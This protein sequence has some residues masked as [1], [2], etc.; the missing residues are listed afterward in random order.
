MNR[1]AILHIPK[2]NYAFPVSKRDFRVR[3]RAGKGDLDRVRLVIGNQYLWNTR[4]EFEMEKFGSDALFD[5]YEVEYHCTDTR[6]GYYF[7]LNQG[8]E[9]LIY[10]ENGFLTPGS[11]DIDHDRIGFVHFQFPFI[12]GIDVHKK[13]SWVNETVFYQIF[14]ERFC[15]GDPALSPED[16]TPWGE[17]PDRRNYFG[18]DLQGIIQKLPYLADLGVNAL[19]LTPI[20]EALS[21]HKYDTI[22]YTRIDPHF[23]DEST[24]VELVQKAH[25]KGIRIMLDGVFNHC[26]GC[27][28]QFQD[29]VAHGE[30]SPY[31]DWFHIHSFPVSFDPL[32]FEGFGS[33]A[34]HPRPEIT[35]EFPPEALKRFCMPKLNTENPEVKEYLL[36]AVAKWTKTG[37]DG[38]RLDVADEVDAHFWRDFRE[39]VRGINPDAIIIGENWWNAQPWLR[40]DQF[41]GVMNY[42]V[43]RS[44]VLYFAE[45]RIGPKT[46]EENLTEY[47][48]RY[49]DQANDSMLN[50]LDSHDTARFIN[51]CGGNVGRLKNAAA[52]QYTYV[53]MPCTYY[54]TEIGMTGDND[55]DCRKTFDWNQ[56]NWNQELL[57]YYKK[58]IA[59]RKER[60]ALQEGAVR[61]CSTEKVFAMERTLKEE[62]LLVLINNTEE[63]QE[64][65]VPREKCADLLNGGEYVGE[66]GETAVPVPAYSALVLELL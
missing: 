16:I 27:F 22:D 30:A 25:E 7:L 58:L 14:P 28:R 15:N 41:D 17:K 12:N 64:Y 1:Q 3:L 8:E 54:G 24:L 4:Q 38:W 52:F 65:R 42:A 66:P 43:Q 6:L 49:T 19:Y 31:K 47:L 60:K 29:V 21:N 20:F 37:I 18:G 13:P 46:F 48:V 40:G 53:G 11:V 45:D 61:F 39:T 57:A 55:P 23:G 32:N 44:S 59:L 5:Y 51:T 63:A 36:G 50:L 33:T 10:T 35:K 9:E 56:E 62:R 2:S 34:F 26:G